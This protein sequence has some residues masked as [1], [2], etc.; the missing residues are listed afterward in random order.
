MEVGSTEAPRRKQRKM[1][2][3]AEVFGGARGQ[4]EGTQSWKRGQEC[5]KMCQKN[6][7]RKGGSTSIAYSSAVPF[8]KTLE[9]NILQPPPVLTKKRVLVCTGFGCAAHWMLKAGTGS[10][11]SL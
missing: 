8:C 2:P 6:A 4:H 11:C 7:K 9:V 10:F 3:A 5:D 1:G